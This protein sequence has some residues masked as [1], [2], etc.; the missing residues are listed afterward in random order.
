LDESVEHILELFCSCSRNRPNWYL[1]EILRSGAL[2]S[3]T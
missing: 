3:I 1:N 2:I